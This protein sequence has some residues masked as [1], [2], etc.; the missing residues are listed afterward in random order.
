MVFNFH[1]CNY[2]SGWVSFIG[3]SN[4][5]SVNYLLRLFLIFSIIYSSFSYRLWILFIFWTLITPLSLVCIEKSH[6]PMGNSLFTSFT[7]TFDGQKS[8]VLIVRLIYFVNIFLFI[9]SLHFLV[10]CLTILVLMEDTMILS[11][12]VW[13]CFYFFY[14]FNPDR[15]NIIYDYWARVYFLLLFSCMTHSLS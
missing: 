5:L 7:L 2:W 13:F 12:R 10:F 11:Y 4:F 8:E 3:C 6:P 1:F 9:W 14:I 15:F